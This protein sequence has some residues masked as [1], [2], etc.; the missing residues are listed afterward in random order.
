ME[1]EILGTTMPVLEVHL[2]NGESIIAESGQLS[3][4]SSSISM[5]THT[6]MAGAKG[7]FSVFQRILSSGTLFM[8][9][10]QAEGN[11]GTI[12]FATKVPGHIMR[13]EIDSS[14]EFFVHRHGY[15]CSTPEVNLSLG[16]GQSLG[17]GV[18]GKNGFLLQKISGQGTA[19]IELSGEVI[20]KKLAPGEV[21]YIHPGHVGMFEA[22]VQVEITSIRGIKNIIFGGDGIF[23]VALTG[24]GKVWLQ[25]LPLPN[26]AHALI[27]YL[28][29]KD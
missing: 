11:S 16:F 10:Y 15:L 22:T 27:P 28:P 2:Q 29:T 5:K 25:T 8:T 3:W 19:W 7:V 13:L 21:L 12:A 26:L 18:F 23:L 6:Q 9:Q 20:E 4:M 1:T 17:A 14:K 24:P